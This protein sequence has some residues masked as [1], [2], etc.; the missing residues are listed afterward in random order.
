MQVTNA[1]CPTGEIFKTAAVILAVEQRLLSYNTCRRF[2]ILR[3]DVASWLFH[4]T[5]YSRHPLCWR[6]VSRGML[7]LA[8]DFLSS[9]QLE[10][11]L[12]LLQKKYDPWADTKLLLS[13][14]KKA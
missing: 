11:F 1:Y 7:L 12:N 9:K 5:V 6:A 10:G 8:G 2:L 3:S 4:Y 13:A 14:L